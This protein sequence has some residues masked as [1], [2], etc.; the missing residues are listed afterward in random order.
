MEKDYVQGKYSKNNFLKLF[1]NIIQTYF[2]GSLSTQPKD[3]ERLFR[4][5]EKKL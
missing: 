3:V 4:T 5:G 1:S 2:K